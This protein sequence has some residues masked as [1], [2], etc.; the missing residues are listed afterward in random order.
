MTR[1]LKG[2]KYVNGGRIAWMGEEGMACRGGALEVLREMALLSGVIPRGRLS[3]LLPL[4]QMAALCVLRPGLFPS[5][6]H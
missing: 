1:S 4:W 2:E 3:A 5:V 6:V